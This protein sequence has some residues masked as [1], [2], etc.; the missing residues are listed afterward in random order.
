MERYDKRKVTLELQLYFQER[1]QL[2]AT[3]RLLFGGEGITEN[4]DDL[5]EHL[6]K[7]NF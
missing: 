7:D 2:R 1:I 3:R 4:L 6:G 5:F